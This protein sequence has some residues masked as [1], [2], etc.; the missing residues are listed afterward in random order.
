MRVIKRYEEENV[1]LDFEK[2]FEKE[3]KHIY[4]KRRREAI[5]P[6]R[7]ERGGAACRDGESLREL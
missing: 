2:L 4:V 1:G 6:S 3:K 7:R 5:L